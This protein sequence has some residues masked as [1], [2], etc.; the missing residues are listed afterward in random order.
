MKVLSK[1]PALTQKSDGRSLSNSLNRFEVLES[2][3]LPQIIMNNPSVS[4]ALVAGRLETNLALATVNFDFSLIK[5]QPPPEFRELGASLSKK[6]QELA[7]DGIQHVTARKLGALFRSIL[8]DVQSLESLVAAYG[9]RVSEI[10]KSPRVNPRGTKADGPFQDYVGADG[11]SIWAAATSGNEAIMVHLLACMLA[12]MWSSQEATSIW[13]EVVETRKKQLQTSRSPGAAELLASQA[14]ITRQQLSDWDSSARSWLRIADQA[15]EKQQKQLQLIIQKFGLDVSNKKDTYSS[16]IDAWT[17]ALSTVDKLVRG[18]AQN[19]QNGAVLLG[20]AAWHIYPDMLALARSAH[21]IRQNDS[22]IAQGG[23]LTLGV[24]STSPHLSEGIHWSLPLAYMRFYGD[25]LRINKTIGSRPASV[26]PSYLS[27][28]A[29]GCVCKF[30]SLHEADYES[31]TQFFTAIYKLLTVGGSLCPSWLK[32]FAEA[33][34]IYLQ[35]DV[36]QKRELTKLI[37]YGRRRA[38]NFLAPKPTQAAPF[39]GLR[40]RDVYFSLLRSAEERIEYLRDVAGAIGDYCDSLLIRYV[41]TASAEDTPAFGYATCAPITPE[42]VDCDGNPAA[43]TSKLHHRWFSSYQAIDPNL[44]EKH[45]MFGHNDVAQ[46]E[47]GLEWQDAPQC[48]PR[49]GI[50]RPSEHRFKQ[51][52]EVDDFVLVPRPVDVLTFRFVAGDT[53]CAGLYTNALN[54]VIPESK[55]GQ[56]EWSDVH[57]AF[58]DGKFSAKAMSEY[59]IANSFRKSLILQEQVLESLEA[60]ATVQHIYNKLSA[61]SIQMDVTLRPLCNAKWVPQCH[62]RRIPM[63]II[64]STGPRAVCCNKI[65]RCS[66]GQAFACIAMMET[67]GMDCEPEGLEQVMALASG[68]SMYVASALLADPS[69]YVP[70]STISHVVGNL[71]KA[72]LALL[73]PARNPLMSKIKTEDWNVINHVPFDS[74]DADSFEHTSMHLTMTDYIIPFTTEHEG[75]RDVEAFFQE[76]L[77]SVYDKSNWVAD[78]DVLKCLESPTV[79]RLVNMSGKCQHQDK[80]RTEF[81]SILSH[82]QLTSID[83]WQEFIDRPSKAA[84][85]RAHNNWLGRLAAT[86]MASQRGDRV[87]VLNAKVCWTCLRDKLFLRRDGKSVYANLMLIR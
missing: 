4:G 54:T 43:S 81:A 27:L 24:T 26:Q 19:V 50:S 86:C 73:I 58:T 49:S 31:I 37:S 35:A 60:L 6:R 64:S 5:V 20:L 13:H 65:V 72:G 3:S 8:P 15:K 77:V 29:M 11:T 85:F 9:T 17:S 39:F 83:S 10:A 23:I 38:V 87:V 59:L 63:T 36:E 2:G 41:Y 16:V 34:D 22:L 42:G 76:A 44:S 68:A 82:H 47:I 69:D 57:S 12:R 14:S 45:S 25:P 33:A 28:I 61:T 75:F 74:K 52:E 40:N 1:T 56:L 30:W 70:T 67:G 66:R 53:Y 79:S 80:H 55:N 51:E 18:V 7:E 48:F 46:S 32:S 71:G 84:I 78:L 62:C 21:I